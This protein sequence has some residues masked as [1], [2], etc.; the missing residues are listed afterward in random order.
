VCLAAAFGSNQL[1]KF[2]SHNPRL[3]DPGFVFRQSQ[4]GD[5]P[6]ERMSGKRSMKVAIV[7]IGHVARHQI[8]AIHQLAG[9]VDLVGAYDSDMSA[10][11]KRAVPCHFHKSLDD[12]IENSA[13][14][15]IVVATSNSDH[16]ATTA[17]L[18]G[19]GRAVMVEKPVCENR[20]DL[21]RLVRLA[22]AGNVFFHVAFH[23]AFAGDLLWWIENRDALAHRYGP[24]EQFHMDCFDP[25]IEQ[26]GSVRKS[27][28]GL[29]GS[30]YDSG[31]NALSVLGCIADAGSINVVRGHMFASAHIGCDQINGSARFNCYVDGE[32]CTGEI[33][34]NWALG[35]DRK[36]T[37]LSYE[38][39]TILLDHSHEQVIV[40]DGR[41][42]AEIISLQNG[43]PRLTNHYMGVF[44]DL[45]MSFVQQRDN[46]WLSTQLHELLFAAVN[47][48]YS[49]QRDNVL[50]FK[51]YLG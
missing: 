5:R 38:R 11:H 32:A 22:R 7:G 36:T 15:V 21:N 49:K 28:R 4:A 27:A 10:P 41:E 47:E 18:L 43:L 14:D 44:R 26:D 33:N 29:G 30:W 3:R 31:I 37:M 17:R 50:N 2:R 25:Y 6:R 51:R 12:L 9:I 16:F 35:L 24:I 13:A 23:A 46:I 1:K 8:N 45:E 34:T 42:P 40:R 39:A 19:A 20:E 48:K